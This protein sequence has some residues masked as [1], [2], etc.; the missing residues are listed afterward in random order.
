MKILIN[1]FG[2]IGKSCTRQIIAN[3]IAEEI[4]INDPAYNIDSLEYLIK[5]DSIYGKL[6]H[7]IIKRKNLLIIKNIKITFSQ[8][9]IFQ[10]KSKIKKYNFFIESSGVEKNYEEIK[11]FNKQ[12]KTN[13]KFIITH[14]YGSVDHHNIFGITENNLKKKHN[15]F[16][17]SICDAVAIGPV[18]NL[19]DRSLKIIDGNIL[20]LHP[21]LGYQNL[22]DGI[23]RSFA[24]P[25]KIIE[26]FALGRASTTN[27]IPKTTS[28]LNALNYVM[29][30]IKKKITSMSVRV[31]TAIVS[32]A[33][34]NLN[35]KNKTSKKEVI[36]LFENSV[37]KQKNKILS[38]EY[39]QIVS[40]DII[41]NEYSAVVDMRW[42]DVNKNKCRIYLWYDNEY[43]YTNKVLDLIKNINEKQK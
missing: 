4:H 17:S 41:K 26:N 34:I 22:L 19:L 33:I 16:S 14:A 20:T 25:G 12:I 8:S 37:K 31:P 18:L 15:L 35:F 13:C 5:Y 10:N 1:G 9:N 42:L 11:N 43:G 38:L 30:G 24:Y 2:R 28:C 3:E 29:P 40:G 6:D 27:L 7:P 32:A 21:W 36:K 23:S 39:D